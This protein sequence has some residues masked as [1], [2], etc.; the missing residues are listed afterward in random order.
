V[1]AVGQIELLITLGISI[2]YFKEKTNKVEAL[3]IILL[4]ISIIM[5]LLD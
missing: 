3:A 2:F 4:A 5:I 1:R